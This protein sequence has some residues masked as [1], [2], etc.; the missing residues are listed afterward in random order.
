MAQ[1]G[2]DLVLVSRT[3]AKLD[4]TADEIKQ[5]YSSVE[6]KTIAFDF[7][8]PNLTDYKAK[9]LNQLEQLEVGI[10]GKWTFVVFYAFVVNNVGLSYEYPERLE[11]LD[12]GLERVTDITVINTLP[13]TILSAAILKQMVARNKGIIVNVSSS[14]AY[15]EL[16][17]WA[18]YSATK[19]MKRFQ[20]SIFL[21]IRQLVFGN[22]AQ[23]IRIDQH[24]HPNSLSHD[25]RYENV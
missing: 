16:F 1:R 19:V 18:I 7:S 13:A 8:N 22:F 12:G 9:V 4:A 14:A 24:C 15:H 2:F 23:G 17:Y 20:N 21:E 10:L 6:V 3:Q 11:R 5:H 25:G